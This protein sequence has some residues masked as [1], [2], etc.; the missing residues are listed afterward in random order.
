M[1]FIFVNHNILK[2]FFF[3]PNN[4]RKAVWQQEQKKVIYFH[5]E[6]KQAQYLRN[7]LIRFIH[8]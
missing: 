8:F 4:S 2:P 6:G 5:A 1:R 3:I 7:N